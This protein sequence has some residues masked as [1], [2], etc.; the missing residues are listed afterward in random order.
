VRQPL[1]LSLN[2]GTVNTAATYSV[3]VSLT[4]TF[5]STVFGQAGL[6][7]ASS[8]V[9]GLTN[10]QLYY[11]EA[12]AAN[13]GGSGSWSAVWSFTTVIAAAGVPQLSSP[14]NG[15]GGVTIPATLAWQAA[16]GAASYEVQVGTAAG[17]G[18]GTTVFDQS[19]ITATSVAV[20]SIKGS[21]T[22]YWRVDAWNDAGPGIWS[23]IWD[24]GTAVTSVL[25]VDKS[26]LTTDFAATSEALM[27][28]LKDPGNVELSFT[29]LLGKTAMLVNRVLPAGRYTIA[30]KNCDLA[31]GRYIVRFK[32]GGLDKRTML[33]IAR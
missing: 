5:S 20:S 21:N 26:G 2:W 12:Q 3:M 24:F 33:M 29:D 32:A 23:Q 31:A 25:A 17:F 16:I 19:G 10:A 30:L 9:P 4:S 14:G 11:W 8:T 28:S 27:Y 15:G 1:T 6:T 18:A 22:Y 7:A 13:A